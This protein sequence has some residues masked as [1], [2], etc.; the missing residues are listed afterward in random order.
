[1][2]FDSTLGMIAIEVERSFERAAQALRRY[3]DGNA[4]DSALDEARRAIAQVRGALK[5]ADVA[6]APR[7]LLEIEQLLEE[8]VQGSAQ[9]PREPARIA[10]SLEPVRAGLDAVRRYVT[11]LASGTPP[12]PMALARNL[13]DMLA[14]RGSD[15]PA[16]LELF[17]ANLSRRLPD[18][19]VSDSAQ[20]SDAIRDLRAQFQKGLLQWLHGGTAGLHAMRE[21]VARAHAE[22]S[23]PAPWWIAGAFIDHLD[24][25]SLP[26]SVHVKRVFAGLDQYF[27]RLL[28]GSSE[29]PEALMRE[30]LYFIA[31]GDTDSSLVE[32]VRDHYQVASEQTPRVSKPVLPAQDASVLFHE[33][34]VLWESLVA[35]DVASAG[36]FSS[37]IDDTLEQLPQ[38]LTP[39]LESLRAAAEAQALSRTPLPRLALEVASA[40]LVLEETTSLEHDAPELAQRADAMSAR[41]QRA[42]RGQ[43]DEVHDWTNLTGEGAAGSVRDRNL[44]GSLGAELASVLDAVE[45]RLAAYFS[46]PNAADAIDLAEQGLM[47][48]QGALQVAGD[49]AAGTA[50]AYCIAAIARLRNASGADKRQTQANV[51][52]IVSALSVYVQH[53]GENG[54]ELVELLRRAGA[55]QQAFSMPGASDEASVDLDLSF[56][57]SASDSVAS[58]Q[59]RAAADALE[60]DGN[61]D[62]ASDADL[63]PVFLEEA[64]EVLA[65]LGSA[66]ACLRADSGDA[67][68]LA[69]LRRGFHTLKGSGRMLGLAH[70]GEICFALER[71]FDARVHRGDGADPALMRLLDLALPRMRSWVDAL[72]R[73]ASVRIEADDLMQLIGH[74]AGSS[75]PAQADSAPAAE[76]AATVEIGDVRISQSLFEVF[77]VEAKRITRALS[78]E[79]EDTG[80]A[81]DETRRQERFRLAHTL[82]G[83]AGT[84][85]FS[86]M[87]ELAGALEAVFRPDNEAA[88]RPAGGDG[89]LLKSAADALGEMVD[90]IES[91][92]APVA[93]TELEAGLRAISQRHQAS[94]AID[95][96]TAQDEDTAE[97]TDARTGEE[98]VAKEGAPYGRALQAAVQVLADQLSETGVLEVT[99]ATNADRRRLRMRDDID[100]TLLPA[101][102]EEA[103]DLVPQIGEALRNWRADPQRHDRHRVLARLV[104]TFKGGARMAGAMAL[105]ELTHSMET[106]IATAARLPL[107]PDSIFD[108]LEVSFDRMGVLLERIVR[109]Q[110]E[111][112]RSGVMQRP[113]AAELAPVDTE[114]AADSSA[115]TL[116]PSGADTTGIDARSPQRATRG[117]RES[118]PARPLLRV[119]VDLLERLTTEAGEL[120]ISR[121]RVEGELR[122]MRGSIREM[123]A[124]I[125][126][127]RLQVREMEI[128][129]E[130]QIQSRQVQADEPEHSLDPLELDRFTRLQELTRL[131]DESAND[132]ASLQQ[133]IG[134]NIDE[135]DSAL[136]GQARM[137]RVLQD[138]LVSVRMVPFSTLNE[139]LYRVVRLTARD[140]GRRASLDIRGSS[141]E[142][143]R[144]M[145]DRIASPL[146]H[147]L[148]NAVVHGIETPEE[149]R[150]AGKEEVGE[151]ALELRQEGNEILLTLQDDGR[152]FDIERLRA[153]AVEAGLLSGDSEAS[154]EQIVQLAFAP[155]VSTAREVSESAGRGVGLDVVRSELAAVGGRVEVSFEANR[156][157]L[158]TIRLPLTMTLMQALVVRC[159]GQL[160]ALPA[161]MVEQVRT[162]KPNA[163]ERV[164]ESSEVE[165]QENRYPLHDLRELLAIS[166]QPRAVQAFTPVALVRGGTQRAAIR[167][168]ELVAHEEVVM[169]D[170]GRQLASVTGIVGA[171]VRGSGEIVLILNPMSLVQRRPQDLA[172]RSPAPVVADRSAGI[173]SV[174]VVD[175]SLT[176]RKIT[177]RVLARKGYRVIEARDGLEALDRLAVEQPVLVLLDIEMPRM[178]G[179]EVLKR[180]RG[181][182]RWRS[183]PVMMIT[184]RTAEKHRMQAMELGADAFLGKPFEEQELL[185]Q[186]SE[187]TERERA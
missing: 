102:L 99:P 14:A 141:A 147:L 68:A 170:I 16:E 90:A 1:M 143:D 161:M 183:L 117:A 160:F 61:R 146:E 142:L 80:A 35:G 119:R 182:A 100:N 187:L 26:A 172:P 104:H 22:A 85:G 45:Q 81:I 151:V 72:R 166:S 73:D 125:A 97:E 21:V 181:D 120:G 56:D 53:L 69:S 40:L 121:S 178:D 51:A 18:G 63:L 8:T 42:L 60:D 176:V 130:S 31:L 15:R 67:Q 169:K 129:A 54:I 30:M 185:A 64:D 167:I 108:G 24:S 105:G 66:V 96:D 89:S 74:A 107:F 116:H 186:V 154:A 19:V 46:D 65:G 148:R 11:E 124:S 3:C 162:L 6:G 57:D 112:D 184:S 20:D 17:D 123:G 134:R 114:S 5:V 93:R 52:A 55:P 145:V 44:L 152:G 118:A 94:D 174:L 144:G 13:Q 95:P 82:C 25:G 103:A 98:A 110:D 91:R 150:A 86:P 29:M 136:A 140:A 127:L 156:G 83:I 106:R 175:D 157:S 7:V 133:T 132:V 41:V 101:F 92:Q 113:M 88:A 155:G 171:A 50:L 76:R 163:L 71:L 153:R 77:L 39:L 111:Q 49:S 126:R 173:A 164:L 122:S 33:L 27:A 131:I 138:S 75:V 38:A 84:T 9:A 79:L 135:C 43:D 2:R 168:D 115:Q 149:R 37:K 10:A 12:R 70:L 158:F 4:A 34:Q 109:P 165:W 28:R 180:M 137:T 78:T 87:C 128:Q 23:E 159:A 32:Q 58:S 48:A 59:A 36:S 179:F 62:I 177:G 139:R 47:Q